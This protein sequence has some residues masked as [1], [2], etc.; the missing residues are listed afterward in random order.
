MKD[1]LRQQ[2]ADHTEVTGWIADEWVPREWT[3]S[4][5]AADGRSASRKRRSPRA[6]GR[7]AATV[8]DDPGT[9]TDQ[10]TRSTTGACVAAPIEERENAPAKL[11]LQLDHPVGA[12]QDRGLSDMGAGDIKEHVRL[13][14]LLVEPETDEVADADETEKATLPYYWDVAD[15][16]YGHHGEHVVDPVAR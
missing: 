7:H 8:A 6:A 13:L 3:P 16:A 14:L 15:S 5:G 12:G 2:R 10:T 4:C 1:E 11:T 9:P